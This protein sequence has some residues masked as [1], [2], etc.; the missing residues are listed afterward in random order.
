[1]LDSLTRAPKNAVLRRF[2]QAD[3]ALALRLLAKRSWIQKACSTTTRVE[4]LWTVCQLP[5]YRK[6][7][8]EVH[9]ELLSEI[10]S[11]LLEHGT[12]SDTWLTRRATPLFDTEGDLETLI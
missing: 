10:F 8:P 9:A 1:M 7:L 11:E 2:D 5:D 4:L 6:L 12:L 3:D